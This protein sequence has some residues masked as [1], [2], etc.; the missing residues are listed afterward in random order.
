MPNLS[1]PFWYDLGV[2]GTEL[3]DCLG[4][5]IGHTSYL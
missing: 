5:V 1:L 4:G 2:E 3:Y